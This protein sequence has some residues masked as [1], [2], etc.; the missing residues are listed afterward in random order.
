MAG[1]CLFIGKLLNPPDGHYKLDVCLY[2]MLTLAIPLVIGIKT[3]Q[4]H[5]WVKASIA[6]CGKMIFYCKPM[7]PTR[8][9]R[10]FGRTIRSES[11]AH[12]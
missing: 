7:A 2:H 8:L 11:G 12:A 3:T 6:N 4:T 10:Y 9:C 1:D 5:T